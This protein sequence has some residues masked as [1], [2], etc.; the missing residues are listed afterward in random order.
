MTAFARHLRFRS[1]NPTLFLEFHLKIL[2][3]ILSLLCVSFLFA[4]GGG[5]SNSRDQEGTPTPTPEGSPAPTTEPTPVAIQDQTL[6]LSAATPGINEGNARTTRFAVTDLNGQRLRSRTTVNV[7]A[8]GERITAL[9][10]GFASFTARSSD[11]AL[12]ADID[13][14]G[15]LVSA[16]NLSAG[17]QMVV[18]L[19]V[20]ETNSGAEVFARQLERDGIGSGLKA[21]EKLDVRGNINQAYQL[22][23]KE[24]TQYRVVIELQ[25]SLH[26]DV[27]SL[28]LIDCNSE[29]DSRGLNVNELKVLY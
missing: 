2:P 24:G 1:T 25:C 13:W 6:R 19:R 23:L 29:S 4:C 16:V 8:G 21:L 3:F 9:A 28:A 18:T 7:A 10:T 12:F 11:A 20:R 17:T 27:L 15:T 5:S 26:V 14:H 22:N